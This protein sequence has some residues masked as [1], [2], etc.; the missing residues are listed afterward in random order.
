[1]E[2]PV[3]KILL[4]TAF[5]SQSLVAFEYAIYFS[6]L[7]NAEIVI[8]HVVDKGDF[9][10]R[11]FSNEEIEA[12]AKAKA[13]EMLEEMILKNKT[14][15]DAP[16][17][18]RIEFGKPYQKILE[19]AQEIKPRLI[20]MGKTESATLGKSLLGS[21]TL[22]VTCEAIFPILTVRSIADTINFNALNK[23]IVVPLDLTQRVCEQLS[24]AIEY[25]KYLNSAIS[26]V[27][28]LNKKSIGLEMQLIQELNKAKLAVE[29]EGLVCKTSLIKNTT[30]PIHKL[31]AEYAK[32]EAAHLLIIM[33]QEESS[34]VKYFVGSTAQEVINQSETPVL[35]VV[36]WER[37]EDSIFSNIVD[38]M[39]VIL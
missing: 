28:V 2:T 9:L 8:L 37:D 23:V 19:V 33:T 31:I 12:K 6:K 29:K 27:S 1:M 14:Q 5:D 10:A 30:E 7:T 11:F 36:P 39:G 15:L 16:V 26:L 22:H 20:M 3:N 24:A 13:Q 32:N 21:N 35:S 34:I 17:T 38:P 4:A 25:G 18:T